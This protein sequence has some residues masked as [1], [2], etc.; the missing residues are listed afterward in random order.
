MFDAKFVR[1]HA[2]ELL[3]TIK[4]QRR[5]DRAQELEAFL[6]DDS[7]WRELK[8]ASDKLRSERN[9]LSEEV[10]AAKK[11]GADI[12]PLIAKVKEIPGKIKQTEERMFVLE[13][14]MKDRL[15]RIPNIMHADVPFGESDK[16]N[17]EVKRWGEPKEFAF[18][19]KNHVELAEGL[20][21]V[22]FEASAKTTGNG[23][24]FLKGDLGL[25]NQALIRFAIDYMR[26]RKYIY[27]EPPLLV[28]KHVLDAAMDT[29]GFEQ[30]IYKLA[31]DEKDPLCLVGTA[32]HA[33]LGMHIGQTIPEEQLPLKYF[34]Y[35]MSFRQ[36]IGSHG[37][38]EKGLWRTHQFNKVEQFVFCTPEQSWK[39]YDD[40]YKNSC[41]I[42]EALELPYRVV[43]I[44]TGDLALWK[45]RS[46]DFEVWRPTTKSYG[47]VMSL[48]NCTTYQA[49]DLDIRYLRKNGERGVMHTLNDTALATSR[50]LVAI[51]ENCQNEDGSIT[52]PKVLQTYIGRKK[53]IKKN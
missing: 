32:E 44:C 37:I 17:P 18:P 14:A 3:E 12:A 26:K 33:I 31:G 11:A 50:I 52:I 21:I 51:L 7:E 41:A 30:S 38:N 35:S 48:S 24:Y 10:N 8:Q 27:I 45:A 16:D 40:L 9:R 6:Q 1:E 53:V 5:D 23:F 46:H 42:L 19:V 25:L 13:A 15:S 22:D 39:A 43:E 28:R 49:T 2:N 20:G 34:G 4:R 29:A 36:E 47:E